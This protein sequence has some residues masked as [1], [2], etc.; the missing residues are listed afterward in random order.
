MMKNKVSYA[1]GDLADHLLQT[2][3]EPSLGLVDAHPC[4]STVCSRRP[5]TPLT[6]FEQSISYTQYPS[7]A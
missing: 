3:Y 5:A 4:A 1:F 6:N 7:K 2:R